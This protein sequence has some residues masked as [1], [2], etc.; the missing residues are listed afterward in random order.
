MK[1][2][3]F[4][5]EISLIIFLAVI[6]AIISLVVQILFINKIPQKVLELNK[7]LSI[8]SPNVIVKNNYYDLDG[9]GYSETISYRYNKDDQNSAIIIESREGKDLG[10]FNFGNVKFSHQFNLSDRTAIIGDI[11]DDGY[12]EIF[13]FFMRNDSLFL[14][15]IDSKNY[16]FVFSNRFIIKRP[17]VK[18]DIPWDIKR[19]NGFVKD[20]NNDGKKDLLFSC[21]VGF[22]LYPRDLFIYD[23]TNSEFVNVF[24]SKVNIER[25]LLTDLNKDNQNELHFVNGAGGNHKDTSGY[26]DNHAWL[27]SLDNNLSY[28]YTPIKL[29]SFP[30]RT[31]LQYSDS[32][33]LYLLK[34]SFNDSLDAAI[35]SVG[36]DGKLKLIKYLPAFGSGYFAFQ[37]YIKKTYTFFTNANGYL[38][39]FEKDFDI[40]SKLRTESNAFVHFIEDLDN[41]GNED[42][43]ITRI[44]EGKSEIVVTDSSL[45]IIAQY[46]L[47]GKFTCKPIFNG[48]NNPI[49]IGVQL[50]DKNIVLNLAESKFYSYRYIFVLL[51]WL[52]LFGILYFTHLFAQKISVFIQTFLFFIHESDSALMLLKPNGKIINYNKQLVKL[53]KT[54]DIK[55]REHYS[56]YVQNYSDIKINIGEAL[57]S[58][59]FHESSVSFY[60]NN[61]SFK[62]KIEITPFKSFWGFTF[63]YLV[64][65]LDQ[66][67]EIL[68]ERQQVWT[69]TAQKIAHEIKTPLGSIQLNLKA[70]KK[71][72]VKNGIEYPKEIEGD[73]SVINEQIARLKNLTSSFLKITNLEKASSDKST[74]AEIVEIA[75][76]K[77]KSY[78]DAGVEIEVDQSIKSYVIAGDKTQY[79]EVMQ[80][81]LENAIDAIR[82]KGT[83]NIS[84]KTYD[85]T[86]QLEIRDNGIGIH[87]DEIDKV[88]DPYFT[89]KKEGTG[90]GLAFAK[91]IMDDNKGRIVIDSEINRGT[92]VKLEF[93]KVSS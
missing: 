72:L 60:E 20:L 85:G 39:L 51:I 10:Q 83:I 32:S 50:D 53:I 52:L 93:V 35:Y 73:I 17:E 59:Q 55:K 92:S 9:D 29:G 74:L 26:S 28:N 23:I 65:I 89:T 12:K 13:Q 4:K 48:L 62:G 42:L 7:V 84:A 69:H 2:D 57:S 79:V 63:A 61:E 37:N 75:T 78:F 24:S 34:S 43:I 16:Q 67:E 49:D 56:K 27:F 80:I 25:V 66:T 38:I 58:N 71:R 47:E 33:S 15:H 77:F 22:A 8:N 19:I 14:S 81:V 36:A 87:K 5:S 41:D 18:N 54:D 86:V 76:A 64:K 40:K 44:I 68:Q 21:S 45:N 70:L 90:L 1:L 31:L 82:A 46:I 88:F 11:N 30:T 6:A 91:K 3:F